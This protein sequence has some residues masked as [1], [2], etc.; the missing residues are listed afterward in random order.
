MPVIVCYELLKSVAF[1][2]MVFLEILESSDPCSRMWVT[3]SFSLAAQ[4]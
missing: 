1:G 2:I 4:V 3:V